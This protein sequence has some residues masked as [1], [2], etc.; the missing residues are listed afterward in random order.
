MRLL[1]IIPCFNEQHNIKKVVEELHRLKLPP[2]YSLS[3][4]VIND[5]STDQTISIVKTLPCNYLDVPVNLG[6]WGA[7]QAGFVFAQRY[8]YDAVVRVDG[9]GQHPVEQIPI[10]LKHS[11]QHQADVVIGSRFIEHNGYQSTFW[12]RLGIFFLSKLA[13]TLTGH[14]ITDTTSGFRFFGHKAIA[15]VNEH[16]KDEY[17]EA[18]A[19]VLFVLMGLKVV[20][21]PVQ[22]HARTEGRSFF[23]L[24]QALFF[25]AKLSLSLI[26]VYLRFKNK[27]YAKPV[28]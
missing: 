22:M 26:F 27:Q 10:L 11:A 2:C 1:V 4:L 24:W 28:S 3:V 17:P 23:T 7:V 25:M 20:E 8:H 5:A 6:I 16:F 14:V 9:D 13:K 21:V 18:A 12:R 15:L 19:D